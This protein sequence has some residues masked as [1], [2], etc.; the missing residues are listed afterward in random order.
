MSYVMVGNTPV[1]KTD[2]Y[3]LVCNTVVNRTRAIMSSGINA[4]HEW[5]SYDGKTV[6]FWPNRNWQVIRPDPAAVAG[7]RVFWQ[8][9]TEKVNSGTIKWGP[10][11][12]KKCEC[13]TCDDILASLDAAPNP[14]WRRWDFINNCR[15]FAR[16]ALDGSCLRKGQR[17]SF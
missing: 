15:R 8:W 6:G 17:T 14:G 16:W 10:A 2:L 3:G 11:A 9:D 7:V 4:G 12:G 1:D 13:A 5:I